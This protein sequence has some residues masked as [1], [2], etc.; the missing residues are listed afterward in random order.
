[1]IYNAAKLVIWRNSV[2]SFFRVDDKRAHVEVLDLIVD[3]L[4][5]L[6]APYRVMRLALAIME[7]LQM[8]Y[9]HFWQL[10]KRQ[11][12]LRRDVFLNFNKHLLK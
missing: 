10:P 4:V 6:V 9:E 8:K 7:A 11:L 5:D 3:E 2:A 1:M 12:F